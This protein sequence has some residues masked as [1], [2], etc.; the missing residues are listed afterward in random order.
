MRLTKIKLAGFKTFVDPTTLSF[1]SN[2]TGII[3]PNGCGKSNIID[4]IRWVMGESSARNLRGDSMDDVIFS[5]S[6]SRP[7]V[8]KAFI[9][10]YFDNENNTLDSKFARFS[11]IVIK[12]EVSRDGTSN[13]YLNSTKCRRK[14]I[15][16]V[17]LGTGLGPRS[18][19][20]IEQG[21]I[22]RLVEAKP[23]ELR[24]YLEEAAGISKYKEKRRETE[25]R[26]KHTKDNLNRLNDVMKEIGSQLGKLERQAKA[27]NDFKELKSKER[28]LKLQLLAIKWN[29]YNIDI[30]KLD[31]DISRGNIENEKQKSLLTNKDKLIE[32]TRFKRNTEQE[33]FNLTQGEFYQ[34]GSEIARCEKD[35]EHSQ[36]SESSR[37][38]NIGELVDSINN[39]KKNSLKEKN[40]LV[41]IE[42]LIS[43]NKEKLSD[44]N[45]ELVELNKHKKDSNFALQNWQT[46]YN[47]FISMQLE[48]KNKQEI[49]KTKINASNKSIELIAKRLRILES[50]TINEEKSSSDKN[51]I[52]TDASDLQEKVSSLLIDIERSDSMKN[53]QDKLLLLIPKKIRD[54]SDNF[55]KLIKRIKHLIRSQEEEISDIK[56]KIKDY[57]N[58]VIIAKKVY[59]NL[60][61]EINSNEEKKV[62]LENERIEFKQIIDKTAWKSDEIQKIQNDINIS[63]SS[64]ISEETA[65]QGN[66]SRINKDQ[67]ELEHRKL[68]MLSI[69]TSSNKPSSDMQNLLKKLLNDKKNKEISLSKS[70]TNLS[71]FDDKINLYESEK[72]DLALSLTEQSENIQAMQI[73]LT[74]K[75]TERD[76]LKTNSD[77]P[78]IDIERVIM[79]SPKSLSREE[80]SNDI[81]STCK[82]I[83]S[84]GAINLAAI[85]ELNDQKERKSYLDMQYDD[86]SNSVSALEVSHSTRQSAEYEFPNSER[87][88]PRG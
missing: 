64:L 70:R 22:S 41:S 55:K 5:G 54:I 88:T 29:S 69:N 53:N 9:E 50:Y 23:E 79:E 72:N 13:Y 74:E 49:E 61:K 21:M 83:E 78:H 37:Q 16:E 28:S 10:L 36:E 3:G 12:R 35:I 48:T 67:E 11:E 40:R 31:K 45:K 7:E 57:D 68:A 65:V 51:I 81:T 4:A 30:D 15:R 38:K 32:E 24:T 8:S 63:Q 17:F 62:A 27:A 33:I 86:L 66:I 75:T 58:E 71:T 82:K 14:D 2:L 34:I 18:Y 42:A 39:L 84:L 76:G 19:A 6:S 52:I 56:T 77:L 85:D 60:E 80:V 44:V 20:I 73:N 25:L 46:R 87:R 1:P 26:L 43:K 47:S 59:E